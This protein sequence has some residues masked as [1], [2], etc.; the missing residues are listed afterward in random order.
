MKSIRSL[1]FVALGLAALGL[2]QTEASAQTFDAVINDIEV[3]QAIQ[4]GTT[5]LTAQRTTFVR[6]QVGLTNPP[7][8]PVDLDGIMRVFIN[9]VEAEYSPIYSLNGPYPAENSPDLSKQKGTLNFLFRPPISNNVVLEVEINPAGP[10]FVPESNT[11]NNIT[12]TPT[13]AFL[14]RN[15]PEI[16]YSP[17]D[18]R[19]GGGGT[20]NVPNAVLIEPGSGDN[21]MQGIYPAPDFSYHRTDA[22]SK[23]WTGNLSGSGSSLISSLLSDRNLMV[24]KP[25]FIYGWVPG[26]LPYNGQAFLNS[27][28]AMGNTQSFK[29]QRTFS[30]EVGHNVGLNHTSWNI[31]EFGVDVE[32]HLN[33]TENLPVIKATSLRNIMDAGL[34]TDQAWVRGTHY[35]WFYNHSKFTNIS[36]PDAGGTSLMFT[37]AW[38]LKT[39]QIELHNVLEVPGYELTPAV[40]DQVADFN[41]R[42][43]RAGKLT[44]EIAIMGSTSADSCADSGMPMDDVGLQIMLPLNAGQI[45]RLEILP[46]NGTD[47][48]P[49]VMQRSEGVPQVQFTGAVAQG[50]VSGNGK[51]LVSW[52]AIDIDGDDLQYYL[53]FSNDGVNVT[54]LASGIRATEFEVDLSKLARLRDGQGFFELRASDGLNTTLVRSSTLKGSN[55]FFAD[56]G[57]SPWVFICTPDEG[58]NYKKGASVAFH[59]SSW[60]LED[61]G[62]T[63]PAITWTSSL[64][65][66]IGTGRMIMNAGLS[67]GSHVI[68]VTATDSDAM[69]ATDTVNITITDRDLPGTVSGPTVYCTAGMSASGCVASI[70]ATG[71]PSA[72]AATGFFLDCASVEGQ[73][74]GQFFY[75]TSGQQ[76]NPWGSGTSFQCV[77]PPTKRGGVQAG[78]GTLGGCDGAFSQDLNARWQAKPA[79]NPGAG[80]VVQA[81]FWYRDPQNTSNQTTSLSDAI[82]FTVQP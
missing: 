24:P 11:A 56:A 73:K 30:H 37:G 14:E 44:D 20:P 13:L 55:T 36:F 65:G 29:F 23:L 12:S 77:V 17:I 50:D 71:T 16:A 22:P 32:H 10:N 39:G 3:N 18:Y 19:P 7:S 2:G 68:T 40:S 66:A 25:E 51:V 70:S 75:G 64:D 57:N 6:V 26:G 49:L 63:N 60:D 33:V 52:S 15:T 45:D 74:D 48:A 41:V 43:Y 28:A 31:Q 69:T 59:S 5:P 21:F 72:T 62:L 58:K 35:D 78:N 61:R 81:Q 38:N 82:Q 9:G 79:H 46:M 67:V 8:V 80:A 4:T 54:P 76:A 1:R 34:D 27:S 42:A 47:A 53:T